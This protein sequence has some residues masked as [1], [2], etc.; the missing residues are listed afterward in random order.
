MPAASN[1]V[2]PKR[3]LFLT[4]AVA[5]FALD[6]LTKYPI[7]CCWKLY[8]SQPVFPWLSFTYVQNTGSLFG[9]FQGKSMALGFVSATISALI[10]WYAWHLPR[11]SNW[12]AYITL[13]VLLGGATGNMLDRLAFGFVVDFFDLRWNGQNIWAIFNVADIAVDLAIA[14]FVLM[15]II[16]PGSQLKA[17]DRAEA[18]SEPAAE[19]A[20]QDA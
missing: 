18:S 17:A 2:L 8:Q 19:S 13:G 7:R 1:S 20:Q 10:V 5:I 12:L 11:R 15:A 3:L 14:L 16:E 6:Q 9:I 4:L